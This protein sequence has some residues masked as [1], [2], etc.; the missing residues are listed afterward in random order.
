MAV[1]LLEPDRYPTSRGILLEDSIAIHY[2]NVFTRG[3]RI[4]LELE[5]G[6]RGVVKRSGP[7][8]VLSI[9]GRTVKAKTFRLHVRP[10]MWPGTITGPG[11]R[12]EAVLIEGVKA[13]E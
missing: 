3:R 9:D 8:L 11:G 10:D 1:I 7:V 12:I 5:D 4:I 2:G 13:I 6:R